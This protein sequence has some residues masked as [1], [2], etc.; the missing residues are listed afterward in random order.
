MPVDIPAQ[1]AEG[2]LILAFAQ[3]A[4]ET[5]VFAHVVALVFQKTVEEPCFLVVADETAISVFQVIETGQQ[6]VQLTL[7]S[8]LAAFVAQHGRTQRHGTDLH[9]GAIHITQ[10]ENAGQPVLIDIPG[11]LTHV[12]HLVEGKQPQQ[13]HNQ[14][15]QAEAQGGAQRHFHLSE[16]R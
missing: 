7:N 14:G 5:G 2:I 16:H 3:V 12:R 10:S 8:L 9:D 1:H 11:L 15:N 6:L 13:Q 4:H